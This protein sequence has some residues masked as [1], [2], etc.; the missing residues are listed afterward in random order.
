VSVRRLWA[1]KLREGPEV[2]ANLF[3]DASV[4]D[5]TLE[6]TIRAAHAEDITAT[7]IATQLKNVLEQQGAVEMQRE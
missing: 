5:A 4:G 1:L 2:I 6:L 7:E 3:Y